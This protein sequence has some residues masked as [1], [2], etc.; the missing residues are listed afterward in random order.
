VIPNTA[1]VW[2]PLSTNHCDVVTLGV[3]PSPAS[4]SLQ[5][6]PEWHSF[7]SRLPHPLTAWEMRAQYFSLEARPKGRRPRARVGFLERDSNPLPAA[8]GL[9]SAVTSPS[10]VRG[11]APTAQRFFTIVSTQDGLSWHYNIVNCWLSCSHWGP[12]PP[13]PPLRTPMSSHHSDLGCD[14]PD[15]EGQTFEQQ[16]TLRSHPWPNAEEHFI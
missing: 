7:P 16:R 13:L 1:D 9:G 8:R 5:S 15:V 12:R 3:T 10:V 6:D 14:N 2:H 4:P 11:G